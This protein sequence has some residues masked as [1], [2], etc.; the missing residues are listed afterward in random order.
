MRISVKK[1]RFAA[2][3]RI[4]KERGGGNHTEHRQ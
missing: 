3:K 1:K 2:Q 4:E